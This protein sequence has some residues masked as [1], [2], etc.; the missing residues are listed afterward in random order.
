MARSLQG[1]VHCTLPHT[2]VPRA[3]ARFPRQ[4]ASAGFLTFPRQ[5]SGFTT[6]LPS[7]PA[8]PEHAGILSE[9]HVL[10]SIDLSLPP[11]LCHPHLEMVGLHRAGALCALPAPAPLPPGAFPPTADLRAEQATSTMQAPPF[12]W[13][14]GRVAGAQP[15]K[16]DPQLGIAVALGTMLCLSN[17]STTSRAVTRRN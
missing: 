17:P 2:D 7:N 16:H 4:A 12:S 15:R 3:L 14:L 9:L 10:N 5:G 8:D 6:P 1:S 13:I 11:G